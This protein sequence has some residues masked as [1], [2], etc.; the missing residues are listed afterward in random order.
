[1]K[2]I[3]KLWKSLPEFIK[4]GLWIGFSAAITAVASYLLER[5]ELFNY[6]GVINFALFSIKE[7]DKKYRREK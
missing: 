5:P 7:L 4:V 1:M 6:Y 3:S 2:K